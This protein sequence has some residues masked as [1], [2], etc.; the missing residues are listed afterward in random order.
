MPVLQ[1]I[2]FTLTINATRALRTRLLKK[3]TVFKPVT[4]AISK[5]T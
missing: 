2:E 4:Q 5:K 1:L 3:P